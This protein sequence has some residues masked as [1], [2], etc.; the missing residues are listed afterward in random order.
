MTFWAIVKAE[1]NGLFDFFLPPA[2]PLCGVD[3]PARTR[4]DQLCPRCL[5]AIV[6]LG[7]PRCPRCSL[8]YPTENGTDHLCESCLRNMPAFAWVTAVGQYGGPLR[9]AVHRFKYSEGIFLD[10]CLGCLLAAAVTADRPDFRPDLLI[11]VPLHGKRLRQRTYNQALLLARQL[12]RHWRIPVAA[13][14]LVRRRETTPQQGL[15]LQE[16]RENLH[17]AFALTASVAGKSILLIDDVL[18]TG[19]TADECCRVLRQGGAGPIGIAVLGRVPRE[20]ARLV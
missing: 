4:P 8:P 2:C 14:L 19:T 1:L 7:S 16:R 15:V 6:P 11:P 3:L 17:N 20:G 13:R 5:D 10:R 9:E 18:T 12:G